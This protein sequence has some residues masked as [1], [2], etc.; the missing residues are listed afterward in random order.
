MLS[1][2]KVKIVQV[3]VRSLYTRYG[4]PRQWIIP[5]EVISPSPLQ[6]YRPQKILSVTDLVSPS[7]CVYLTFLHNE[8]FK[9]GTYKGVKSNLIIKRGKRPIYL[10]TYRKPQP[11]KLLSLG[12]RNG[13][14][15]KCCWHIRGINFLNALTRLI[16]MIECLNEMFVDGSTVCLYLYVKNRDV[17]HLA[18]G[19]RKMPVFGIINDEVIVG[20]MVRM[21]LMCF[22]FLNRPFFRLG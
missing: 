1:S 6:T 10:K 17:T 9:I 2:R 16:K 3:D 15:G 14:Y 11:L 4:S 12:R 7:W 20:K 22:K 8:A 5:Q 13:L 18:Y 19:K 21:M